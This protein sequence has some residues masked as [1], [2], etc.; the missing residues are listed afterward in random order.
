MKVNLT[1]LLLAAVFLFT[2]R[3]NAQSAAD[4]TR[5][6]NEKKYQATAPKTQ[7]FGKEAFQPSNSTTIRWLGMAGFLINSRGTTLMI[8]P[9]LEGY[10]MPLLR[11]FPI[12]PKDVPRLDAVFATHSDNDHYSVQTFKDLAPVTKQFH[13]TV[14]VDSLMK[15]EGLRSVGHFIG[16]TFR[17]GKVS[18]RLTLADHAWQNDFP[19]AGQRYFE[20]GDA[21]GFWF[22]TPDGS[23]WAPGDSKFMQEQLHMPAPDAILFY[24]SEDALYHSGLDGAVKIANAYPNTPLILA[25]W[26]FVDAPDFI[27]FNGNPKNL[28]NRVVN[29]QRIIVL[30]P[31][32]PFTLKRLKN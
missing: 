10:D 1:S 9:L 6:K 3:V 7:P 25:H 4:S 11:D 2:S 19:K 16:D 18:V 8:D 30:A 15:N 5:A 23:I 32:Q 13:S 21:C 20:P 14:Y 27:P 29:P 17:V 28:A 26:G 22:N 12:K 31:G 24:Y